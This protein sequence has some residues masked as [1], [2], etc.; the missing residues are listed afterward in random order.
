ME[1][2]S[3][4]YF[5]KCALFSQHLGKKIHAVTWQEDLDNH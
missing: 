3:Q 1:I 5:W 4:K 2:C